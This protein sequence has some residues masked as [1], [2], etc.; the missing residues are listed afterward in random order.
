MSAGV[1]RAGLLML[2]LGVACSKSSKRVVE[3]V[4]IDQFEGRAIVGLSPEQLEAR[5]RKILEASKFTLL[6]DTEKLPEGAPL[7][8][9]SLALN[10]VEPDPQ[11]GPIGRVEG[12]LALTQRGQDESFD[13]QASDAKTAASNQIEDIQEATGIALEQVLKRLVAES[14]AMID[15]S[16]ASDRT[17]LERAA[18]SDAAVQSAA[19]TLLARKRNSAALKPLLRRLEGSNDPSDIRRTMGLLIELKD[20]DAVPALIDVS[21]ARDNIVQREVVFALGAIGGDEAEAYLWSVAQG[22]DDPVIRASAEQALKEL[23]D[24]K[25]PGATP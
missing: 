8:R 10:I 14:K 3:R 1:R 20:P 4:T 21:R 22:H 19:V 13:V 15:L 9:V 6:K 7:W 17:L 11:E 5:L 25:S 24:R 23:K 18:S 2:L 16:S 12:A